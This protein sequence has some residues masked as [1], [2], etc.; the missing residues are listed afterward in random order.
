ME[1]NRRCFLKTSGLLA[2][3]S[4]STDFATDCT[5][6][7]APAAKA[8]KFDFYVMDTGLRGADVPTL[9]SKVQLAKK[10]GFVGIGYT[11]NHRELPRFLELLDKERLE[12]SAV[13]TTPQLEAEIDPGLA[14]SIK[15]MKGRK[16]RIELAIG[17][18]KFK[19]S[20]VEGDKKGV[21]LLK[22]VSD[23]AAETGPVVSIYPHIGSWTERVEDGVRLAK[24]VAR[25]N[26]GTHFN[27]VHWSWVAKK[28]PLPEL[29]TE[30]LPH[31]FAVTINGLDGK[32]IVSLD[33]GDY[34]IDA[35]LALLKK[36]GYHGPV[37]LQGYSVPGPSGEHLQRSM[38][39]W[40]ESIK[41]LQ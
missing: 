37:G 7:D 10:L 32:K 6:A 24:Q 21:D 38:K 19:P 18:K 3:S 17:S 13:Y 36:T 35:F 34:D 41:K 5:A 1:S 39:K 27:L 31:L 28:K 22:A 29:L 8:P 30:A 40:Q 33:Q 16:T 20:E 2:L 23:M 15:H 25:K 26:V 4:L 12:L 11:L 9:E 14:E